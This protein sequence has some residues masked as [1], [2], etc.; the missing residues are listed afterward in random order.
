MAF[1]DISKLENPSVTQEVRLRLAQEFEVNQEFLPSKAS[2][3]LKR[4][5]ENI[6]DYWSISNTAPT[7]I[8]TTNFSTITK[9]DNIVIFDDVINSFTGN[10]YMILQNN[11]LS[12]FDII[13]YPIRATSSDTFNLWIRYLLSESPI[14]P[15]INQSLVDILMD[16]VVMGSIYDTDEVVSNISNPSDL[17]SW[18]WAK[19][20]LV[21]PDT[22]E[23]ILGIKIKRNGTAID[24]IYIEADSPEPFNNGPDYGVS[25]Y[26]TTHMRV[27]DSVNDMPLNPL[28]IYDYKNSIAEVVQDDW[29]NFNIKVLD[30]N[31]GYISANDF[32]ENY[33]LVMSTT[34]SSTDNFIVWEL[35]NND[36]YNAPPSA[37][38]FQRNQ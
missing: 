34:G 11:E 26:L 37:I 2:V 29:Y 5:G 20:T 8:D 36:E 27:Y 14:D 16:G 3:Y 35:V 4:V 32:I 31:H 24:K 17:V 22:V 28:Y 1:I 6:N 30:N 7:V 12:D 9:G 13:N 19:I 21:L 15:S 10:G 23:H 33:F 38:L 25:P 18:R